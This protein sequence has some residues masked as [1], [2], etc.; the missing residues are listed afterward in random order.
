MLTL[1]IAATLAHAKV[2]VVST[3]TEDHGNAR[4]IEYKKEVVLPGAKPDDI[5][6]LTDTRFIIDAGSPANIEHFAIVQW[7]RGCVFTA[8]DSGKKDLSVSRNHFGKIVPFKHSHWQ[9]DSDSTDPI[10]SSYEGNR[11]ALLRWNQDPK[12]TDP[13]TA[14][15]FAIAKPPHGVTFATDLPATAFLGKTDAQNTSLEF[16]TCLFNTTDLPEATTPDGDGVDNTKALWCVSWDHKFVYDF[17]SKTMTTPSQI[18]PFC[19]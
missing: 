19:W 1:L 15:Y 10:Y 11:F 5:T 4:F 9:I 8:D 13:E 2:T 3:R 14:T 16:K 7:I 18:D 17:K 12:N 6:Y